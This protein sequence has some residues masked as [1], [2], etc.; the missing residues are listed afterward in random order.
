MK[1]FSS[2]DSVAYVLV[3]IG[4]INWGLTGLGFNLVEFLLGSMPTLEMIVYLLVGLSG[5][6]VAF[7][8]KVEKK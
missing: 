8:L 1:N 4:A 6:Y 7:G 2:L 5:L 3:I